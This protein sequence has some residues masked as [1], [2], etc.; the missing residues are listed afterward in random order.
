MTTQTTINYNN[1]IT[2]NHT[3]DSDWA[4]F[5]GAYT[6]TVPMEIA[7]EFGAYLEDMH[8]GYLLDT[9]R[10]CAGITS[11]EQD[12]CNCESDEQDEFVCSDADMF[13]VLYNWLYDNDKQCTIISEGDHVFWVWHDIC[14]AVN[15]WGDDAKWILAENGSFT[16]YTER[17]RLMQGAKLCISEGGD[18]AEV[19]SA[20]FGV[21]SDFESRFGEPLF[22]GAH[23]EPYA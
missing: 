14:H 19:C 11:D 6:F 1:G 23:V 22:E 12:E 4:E 7:M 5:P 3:H 18:F 21:A 10:E 9:F 2:I 8:G 17:E 16:A 13:I 15:D 20:L